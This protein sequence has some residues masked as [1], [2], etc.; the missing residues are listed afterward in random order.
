VEKLATG[1]AHEPSLSI[2]A[3]SADSAAARYFA[4]EVLGLTATPSYVL[5]PK[6]SRTFFKYKGRGRDSSSL[7]KFLNMV[8][9]QNEDH[10]WQLATPSDLAGSASAHKAA[11]HLS[12]APA[13]EASLLGNPLPATTS[14]NKSQV[15]KLATGLAHEPSLSICALSADSAAARYF[16]KEVLGLTATPSYVLFPKG[17]RTFFKYK[18]RGRDSSSLL[19]FLNMV[20]NQNEDHMWQLAMPS[21][22]A[23]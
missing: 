4:K 11:Q 21:D 20:C 15:E 5:F 7:L 8:C 23:G 10:M 14:L 3:L 2:C 6:G 1:L 17:S 13:P 22:I 19:K 16:A 18:G 12:I 9:N